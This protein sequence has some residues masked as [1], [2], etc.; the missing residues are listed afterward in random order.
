MSAT[1]V[2]SV[3]NTTSAA[4][5]T[6]DSTALRMPVKSL[7][8][9][10][11]LK[12]LVAQLSAQDPL[13]PQKDTEFIAQV[14]QFSSLEQSRAMQTEMAGLR[15]DQKIQQATGLIGRTV[16]LLPESGKP[17]TGQVSGLDLSTGTPRVVV[18]GLP[19]PLQSVVS[20]SA[21]TTPI[22]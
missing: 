13:N 17:V 2:N 16:T 10:D 9:D 8:Q 6:A 19:F 4:S 7:G 15:S 3:S 14:A 21:P 22:P 12:P 5:T 11:F 20:V 1:S 18:N